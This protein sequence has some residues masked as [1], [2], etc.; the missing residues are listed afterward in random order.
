VLYKAGARPAEAGEFTRRA[1]LN[2]KLD[3]LQA[4]AVADM[5]NADTPAAARNALG[6][7]RGNIS[8]RITQAWEQTTAVISHVAAC[9]DY[10]EDDIPDITADEITNGLTAAADILRELLN[11]YSRGKYAREGV[12]VAIAGPPNAGKSSLFNALLGR[13]RAIVTEI[14]GTTRDSIEESIIING[15]RIIL[16]D[17]AGLRDT[18][19]I[20]EA[21]GVRRSRTLIENAALTLYVIDG[22]Q[23]TNIPEIENMLVVANKSDM[24]SFISHPEWIAISALTGQGLNA[25]TEAISKYSGVLSPDETLLANAR[26]AAAVQTALDGITAAQHALNAGFSPDTALGELEYALDA[27]SEL[28]GKKVNEA[29]LEQIFSQFCV[30]K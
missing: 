1:L 22:T 24:P 4:E 29:V 8:R 21:E 12:H 26:H 23:Q 15:M 10:P 19:D 28:T 7:L 13:D 20:I 6:H 18:D 9:A 5:I 17:T 14:A 11:G 3:L 27:L 30:G 2:G 25:L 16:H